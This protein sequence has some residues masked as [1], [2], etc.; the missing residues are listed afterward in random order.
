[1]AVQSKSFTRMSTHGVVIF[2]VFMEYE[3]TDFQAVNDDGDPDD[4]RLI[5]FYGTNYGTNDRQV[6]VQRGNG[7]NWVDRT[8]PAGSTFSQNA[9]GPVKYESDVPVW[10][11]S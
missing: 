4:F 8:I 2:E 5:R 10:S 3:D 1:M 11:Y 6:T 9:G 7:Q